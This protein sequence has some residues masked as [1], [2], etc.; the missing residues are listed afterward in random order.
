MATNAHPSAE[1]AREAARCPDGRFG[2]SSTPEA[3]QVRL[4]GS[5]A[6]GTEADYDE[7]MEAV[8]DVQARDFPDRVA[9]ALPNMDRDDA[10]SWAQRLRERGMDDELLFGDD[11][12]AWYDEMK[13]LVKDA[14]LSH[15]E[16][17]RGVT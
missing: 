2:P 15:D 13:S 5:V 7:L 3:G 4:G 9:A 8:S 17:D 1:A 11:E 14:C 12:G 16:P 6:G 10:Q